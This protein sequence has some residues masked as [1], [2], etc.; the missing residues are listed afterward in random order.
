MGV[1][2]ITELKDIKYG[3][4]RIKKLLLFIKNFNWDEKWNEN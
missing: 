1:R 2:A 3:H 4:R